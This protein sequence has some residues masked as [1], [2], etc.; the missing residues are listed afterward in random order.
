MSAPKA[1]ANTD[2]EIYRAPS[3]WRGDIYSDS[4]HVTESGAISI[5]CGGMVHVR[6]LR[7]YHAAPDLQ[8]SAQAALAYIE[9]GLVPSAPEEDWSE[10]DHETMA[11]VRALRAALSKAEGQQ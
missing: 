6:P 8:A 9:D 10:Q 1:A 7:F 2:R 5:N 3:D 4:I 11:V